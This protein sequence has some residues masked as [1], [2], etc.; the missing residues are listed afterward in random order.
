MWS[1]VE[2][3]D[4]STLETLGDLKIIATLR[5][6]PRQSFSVIQLLFFMQI[7]EKTIYVDGAL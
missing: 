6:S 7:L 2:E 5:L 1:P 4:A 3:A